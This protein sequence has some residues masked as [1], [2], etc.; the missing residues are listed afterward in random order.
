MPAVT[1]DGRSFML[2]GRRIWL[3]SGTIH[4][5]RVNRA[6]WEERILAARAAGLNCIDVPVYWN[7]HEAR[8]GQFDFTHENDLKHFIS[9]IHAAG[10]YAILRPGPFIGEDWDFGGLPPWLRSIKNI[11][12]RTSN[13][14]Y[15][16]A[17]SRFITAVADQVR[18]LQVTSPKPGPIVLVQ[19]EAG[20]TCGN[21]KEAD[22]Y[23]G[24]L[25][26]YLR[27]AG[28]QVP[29]INSNNLWQGAEGEIDCWTGSGDLLSTIR[30]LAVVRP[31][32]PRMVI[33]YRVGQATT[34][35]EPSPA[36]L[37]PGIL[38]Q[39]L[40]QILA[41]GGQFN[42][43]P[44]HGG[45]NFGFWGGRLPE[46]PGYTTASH[47][48]QAPLDEAGLPAPSFNALRRICTFASRF[49]RVFSNLDPAYRPVVLM[50]A[51][52][53]APAPEGKPRAKEAA[54]SAP[55]QGPVVVH[56]AGQQG[57]IA[58]IFAAPG[59]RSGPLKLL[60][61][62]GTSL[63]VETG[64]QP[65]TWCLFDALLGGRARLDYC[66][67]SAF[68]LVGKVLVLFGAA[69]AAGVVS[70]NGSPLDAVIPK[71]KPAIVQHEGITLVFCTPDQI[72][73]TFI[74]DDA[75]YL[76]AAGLTKDLQPIAPAGAKSC[77]RIDAEGISRA[78]P[79]QPHHAP[80]RAERPALGEWQ[81]A[82]MR[83][84]A[85]GSSARY[86]AID[87][88]ADLGSLGSP[89]GYGWYRIRFKSTAPARARLIFPRSADR[90]HVRLDGEHLGVIGYAPG[91]QNEVAANLK[92]GQHTLVILA[93]NLGRLCSGADIGEPKGLFG[94]VW[95]ASPLKPGKPQ[96]KT[97]EPVDILSF[98]SPLWEIQPGDLT[99]PSRLT[100]TFQ[101]RRKTPIILFLPCFP[102]RGLLLLNGA[103]VA[104]LDQ[105][106]CDRFVFDAEQ[107][108]GGTNTFQVALLGDGPHAADEQAAFAALSSGV[109]FYSGELAISDKAEW[110]FAKWE[111]PRASAFHKPRPGEPHDGPTWWR[112]GFPV[113]E[114]HALWFDA[115][116]LTKGQIY[117]NGKHLCRYFAATA[118]GKAVPPQSQYLIPA[119]WLM[120]G[121][122]EIMVFDEHGATPGRTKLLPVG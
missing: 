7:R 100:W 80:R 49:G 72:D 109:E 88:P 32:R 112:T 119:P 40:A 92:K 63:P 52:T 2:D 14:P 42:I 60:L 19:N 87:G 95:A 120:A 1:Y 111:P 45:T 115:A 85:E 74:T 3:V 24:E 64:D 76:G 86:A 96:V 102:G 20:W 6:H 21:D 118:S 71:A 8:P 15:L 13:G 57:G 56:A 94:H 54:R 33:Q 22:A 27:E 89:F 73:S 50:P 34:W 29:I 28:I 12:F 83:D 78:V 16:E 36:P 48:C 62:D 41:A 90:L 122:N 91:A 107:L 104:Y 26:R 61:P 81:M 58:F 38:Q 30:Q 31:D 116:G 4:Y 9:L 121:E 101:H 79:A 11:R 23:L 77:T 98:R 47:D 5:A 75:V 67:F 117:I 105:G 82:S 25:N 106:A 53:D 108:K 114:P 84:Y 10:L 46:T 43:H 70:I 113:A 93:E 59:A 99:S 17:C 97:G 69:G 51:A 65:V 18:T 39:H 37:D 35:G 55:I 68:A 44:F 110:A 66:S 103:P